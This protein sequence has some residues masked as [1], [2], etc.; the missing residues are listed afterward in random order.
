M[1]TTLVI[2]LLLS[3]T[4]FASSQVM[5]KEQKKSFAHFANLLALEGNAVLEVNPHP[6]L[7]GYGQVAVKISFPAWV[8]LTQVMDVV[9]NVENEFGGVRQTMAWRINAEIEGWITYNAVVE[10]YANQPFLVILLF[11]P[12]T[13]ELYLITYL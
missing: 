10:L 13:N 6:E 8:Q 9:E 1:R 5:C 3:L 4:Q 7:A 12:V 11:I 2:T